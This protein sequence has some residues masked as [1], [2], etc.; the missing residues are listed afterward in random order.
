[1][2]DEREV[3]E[4]SGLFEDVAIRRYIWETARTTEQCIAL[5]STFSSHIAI[6]A[7]KRAHVSA[8]SATDQRAA[9]CARTSALVRD[10]ARRPPPRAGVYLTSA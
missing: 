6:G 1:M 5:I 2:C 3:L 10:S 7:D 8:R 4:A 9:R